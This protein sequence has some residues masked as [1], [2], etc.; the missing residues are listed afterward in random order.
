MQSRRIPQ[1]RQEPRRAER[2]LDTAVRNDRLPVALCAAVALCVADAHAQQV[3]RADVAW[4][5]IYRVGTV[6]E[7][8]DPTS[9]T[10]RRLISAGAELVT[11]TSRIP[12]S[13]GTRLGVGFVLR[14]SPPGQVVPYHVAWRY[15]PRGL[16]NPER[17]T[18]TYEW[19]SPP[20]SCAL[21]RATCFGGY[22]L[23]HAWE[24]VPGTWTIEIWA[25]GKKLIE[26]SFEVFEP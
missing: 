11:E 20:Y 17:R 21:E 16:T 1:K 9:P 12:A 6:R 18:T 4:A 2:S 7:V 23:T 10:G 15:P 24:L 13:I 5:G 3:E 8:E 14:G 19:K 25:D 22:P 26:K